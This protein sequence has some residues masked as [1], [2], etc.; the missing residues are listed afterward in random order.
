M[1][2][3]IGKHTFTPGA[4]EEQ[5][6]ENW[7]KYKTAAEAKGLKTI[8]ALYSREKGFA[9]CETEAASTQEVEQAHKDA[10]VPVDEVIQ[11]GIME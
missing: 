1:P 4:T 11:M 8:H 5:V 9:Y 2:R 7:E 3:F 6:K 10:G